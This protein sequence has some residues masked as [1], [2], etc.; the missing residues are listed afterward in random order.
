MNN[1][2]NVSTGK[3]KIGGSIYRAPFGTA[4]PTDATTALNNAFKP[5]GYISEDG[6]TNGNSP[7][8]ERKKAWGG[9]DVLNY[10]TDKPDTFK[11]KLIE[12]LNVEVLKAVYGDEHVTGDLSTGI[13]IEAN[14][15]EQDECSWVA[16]MIL[17]GN[18]L[19]RI[20]IPK[21]SVTAVGDIKYV[22]NEPI[23]YETTISALPDDKSNTHYEYMIKQA[24]TAT[25]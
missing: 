16:E 12:A 23:G 4:L 9:D 5:L 1:T 20:V 11:F 7:E 2:N 6:L 17:K 25:E 8:T 22:D 24:T 18:V 15:E 3:P 13:T 21:A 10:Q 14:N 19:K